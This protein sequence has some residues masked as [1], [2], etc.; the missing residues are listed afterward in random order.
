MLRSL[1]KHKPRSGSA[2]SSSSREDLF[3]SH[4]PSPGSGRST[5]S[6]LDDLRQPSPTKE[7]L[8]Y[9]SPDRRSIASISTAGSMTPSSTVEALATPSL[10]M[11][12]CVKNCSLVKSPPGSAT[13]G[14]GFVLRGTTSEYKQ[15]TKVYT[16]HVD[17][18]KQ[19]GAAMVR[20]CQELFAVYLLHVCRTMDKGRLLH[21]CCTCMA[22]MSCAEYRILRAAT[23]HGLFVLGAE[24]QVFSLLII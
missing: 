10:P 20:A 11:I 5:P 4:S 8:T 9:I 19:D 16:C 12:V 18:V 13:A 23:Y 14:W 15:G 3:R 24:V 1:K 17:S 22:R 21:A 2:R 6:S 7:G